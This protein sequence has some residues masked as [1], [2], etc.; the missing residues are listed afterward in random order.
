M[1]STA[2]I[3]VEHRDGRNEVV[4]RRCAAPVSIRRCGDRVLLAASAAAPLGGDELELVVDVGAGASADVGSVAAGLVWPGPTAAWSSQTTRCTV[5]ADG[6][7][8]FWLEPTVAVAGSRHRSST[9]VRL[10]STASCVVAEEV[11]LGRRGE[12]SGHLELRL[13]VE[14]GGRVLV[15]H[16]E[17][18]GPDVPGAA[19]AVSVGAAR[20]C[21]SLV[22]VGVDAGRSRTV[23]DAGRAAAWLPVADDAAVVLAVG[24]DRP[25][26]VDAVTRVAPGTTPRVGAILVRPSDQSG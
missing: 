20:H 6:H 9:T 18:F 8:R 17:A 14:R 24:P 16:G 10:D 23:V 13:R 19:S 21:C 11:A 3:A 22:V 26:V 15:D 12:P 25:A 7:L 4:D 2:R 5:D 1:R